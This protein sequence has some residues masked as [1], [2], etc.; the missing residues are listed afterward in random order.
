MPTLPDQLNIALAAGSQW[1]EGYQ[2]L[3]ENNQP[4]NLTGTPVTFSIRNTVTDTSQPALVTVNSTASTAQGYITVTLP[5]TLLIVLSAT[6][7]ALLGQGTRPYGLWTNPGQPNEQAW[8]TGT[9]YSSL[10]ALP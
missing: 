10:V 2:L 9:C 8:I 3:D 5:N 6:A 7:T 1:D 4:I